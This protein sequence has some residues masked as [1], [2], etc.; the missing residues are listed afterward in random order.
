MTELCTTDIVCC[1]IVRTRHFVACSSVN[2]V[3]SY[4]KVKLDGVRLISLEQN[5]IRVMACIA[6]SGALLEDLRN[7]VGQ[8]KT[9][10]TAGGKTEGALCSILRSCAHEPSQGAGMENVMS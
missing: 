6:C 10:I 9:E 7:Y 1:D 2:L 8:N 3:D 5:Y 4:E